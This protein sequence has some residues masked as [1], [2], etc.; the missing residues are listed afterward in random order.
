MHRLLKE[1]SAPARLPRHRSEQAGADGLDFVTLLLKKRLFSSPA[2]FADTLGVHRRTLEL[3]VRKGD[4]RALQRPSTGST[5]MWPTTT[6]TRTRSKRP[7]RRRGRGERPIDASQEELLEEMGRWAEEWRVKADTKAQRIL[8]FIDE[9]CRPAGAGGATGPGTTSGSSSLPST[10][11]PS[12]TSTSCWPTT[13]PRASSTDRVALLYG[14]MDEAARERIKDEFQADPPPATAARAPRHRRRL[15]RHR[16]P[17]ALS[18]CGPRRDPFQPGE[19]GATE[20]PGRSPPPAL[21]E[22]LIYHFI[23][24]GWRTHHPG[25]SKTTC[26]S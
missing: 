11:T 8:D 13:C 20:R 3:R 22:V 10:A 21:A 15:R 25:A 12:S 7:W 6:S 26:S 19:N 1:Y 5:T 14:G 18:P 2:A 9:T 23:G 16:P 4:A 24:A 17:T